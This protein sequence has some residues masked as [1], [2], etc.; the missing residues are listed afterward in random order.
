[1][2]SRRESHGPVEEDELDCLIIWPEHTVGFN[3]ERSLVRLLNRLCQQHGYGR[4]PQLT[5]QIEAL[6][7]DPAKQAE[8]QAQRDAHLTQMEELRA[9]VRDMKE[10]S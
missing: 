1:M 10:D 8:F 6:W 9:V 5:E 2:G 4:I 3:S 7:R